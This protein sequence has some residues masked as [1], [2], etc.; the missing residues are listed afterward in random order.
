MCGCFFSVAQSISRDSLNKL[1]LRAGNRSAADIAHVKLLNDLSD[2]YLKYSVDSAGVAAEQAL[3]MAKQ[4]HD[5]KGEADA[6]L[7]SVNYYDNKA[8]FAKGIETAILCA[9]KYESINNQSKLAEALIVISDLYKKIC[10]HKIT[11]AYILLGLDYS[12]RGYNVALNARDTNNM[13]DALNM[14]GII[15]RDWGKKKDN[16]F[17][18]DSAYNCFIRAL[19]LVNI[20]TGAGETY[21]GKLYNNISQVYA[22]NKKDYAKALSYL[23][24]AIEHNKKYNKVNSLSYNYGNISG[25]YIS[26]GNKAKAL[27]YAQKMLAVTRVMSL[28][29]RLQ[30]AYSQMSRAYEMNNRFDS[31]LY[32]LKLDIAISDSTLN[33]DRTQQIAEMQTKYE[34]QKKQSEIT[35]L[36]RLN[37][38]KTKNIYLLSLVLFVLAAVVVTMVLFYNRIKK[39]KLKLSE[40]SNKLQWMMRELHHR[41]KNNLQIVSSL[42][43]LQTY[44]LTDEAAVTALKESNLRVQ[45][46]SL[47]HQRLYQAEDASL[48]NFKLFVT[49]LTETLM[50]AYGYETDEFDLQINIQEE[51]LAV[52]AVLPLGLMVNEILTNSFKYAYNEVQR[53]LLKISLVQNGQQLE[54]EIA[55]NGPGQVAN[56]NKGFGKS[57]IDAFTRQLHATCQVTSDQGLVYYFQIPYTKQK[58][59]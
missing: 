12:R 48:V 1:L 43:N 15:Y 22:E 39:Q 31:A 21:L 11:E 38:G 37:E 33:L 36:S 45:A 2:A 53:P 18:Y 42:L 57:L 17:Y 25:I 29:V 26:L 23:E 9:S 16:A 6:L 49:D 55:D 47:I 28:P 14:S 41:V 20:A 10:G 8:D 58:I 7:N 4:I 50:A 59:A 5:A 34:T 19:Q 54:M 3:V 27:E 52:D 51:M 13:I 30:S 40:Q 46:M 44:R 35:S 56:E 32:Y 24:K